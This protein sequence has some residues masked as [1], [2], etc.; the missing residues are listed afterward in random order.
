MKKPNAATSSIVNGLL[1]SM[2]LPGCTPRPA[3]LPP[4]PPVAIKVDAPKPPADLMTCADRPAGLPENPDLV[5]QIPTGLRA[6][7]IRL[8]RAFETNA[9][10][11]DLLTNWI[12]PGTCPA[13][14]PAV[15]D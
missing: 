2:A 5:A 7:I 3:N 14:A 13:K 6:G 1:L 11:V 8:A 4:S 12:S 10:R 9:D 15:D